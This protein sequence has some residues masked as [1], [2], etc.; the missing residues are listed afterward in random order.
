MIAERVQDRGVWGKEQGKNPTHHS[1]HI[2]G[3][4]KEIR[5]WIFD[6]SDGRAR[7]HGLILRSDRHGGYMLIDPYTN[8]LAAPGPMSLEQVGLWLDDLES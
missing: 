6:N 8:G 7:R 3:S 1:I 5:K 2:H 4:R